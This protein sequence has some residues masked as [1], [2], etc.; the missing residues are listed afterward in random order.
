ML[1]Y[2]DQQSSIYLEEIMDWLAIEH[3]VMMSRSALDENIRDAGYTHKLLRRRPVERNEV[4][5]EAFR[6]MQRDHLTAAMCVCVDESSKDDR[7]IYRHYGRAASGDRAAIDVNFVRGQRW[8]ILP[9]MSIDGYM[10]VRIIA[11]SVDGLEFLEFIINDVVR[12][13]AFHTHF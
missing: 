12:A 7:T 11:G 13:A 10:A 4:D 8:S 5:R 3:D 1:S 6:D 2:I 9:A